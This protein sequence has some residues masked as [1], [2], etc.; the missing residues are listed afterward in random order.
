MI[1]EIIKEGST[2][3]ARAKEEQKSEEA[4]ERKGDNPVAEKGEAANLPQR[5]LLP[6]KNSM[7]PLVVAK[8]VLFIALQSA[9]FPSSKCGPWTVLPKGLRAVGGT[10]FTHAQRARQK[11]HPGSIPGI[12]TL[13][14]RKKNAQNSGF[15]ASVMKIVFPNMVWIGTARRSKYVLPV[16][17]TS[18]AKNPI[19]IATWG[20]ASQLARRKTSALRKVFFAIKIQKNV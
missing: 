7:V 16:P 1:P 17:R 3:Q 10:L 13:L 2:R 8:E 19:L 14:S 11:I 20:S 5:T 9:G 4:E 6:A 18:T 12:A 15:F